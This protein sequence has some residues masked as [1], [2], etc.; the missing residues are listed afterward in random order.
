[1]TTSKTKIYWE[2]I[3]EY[4]PAAIIGSAVLAFLIAVSTLSHNAVSRD[5]YDADQRAIRSSINETDARLSSRLDSKFSDMDNRMDSKFSIM[6]DELTKELRKELNSFRKE[7]LEE[8]KNM[9]KK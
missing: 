1:M 6:K 3:L 4:T 5:N 2:R 8:I 7:L 9:N